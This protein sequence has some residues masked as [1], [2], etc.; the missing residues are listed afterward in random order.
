MLPTGVLS[1]EIRADFGK[2]RKTEKSGIDHFSE[3]LNRISSYSFNQGGNE[4]HIS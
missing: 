2:P 4:E 1:I 3:R